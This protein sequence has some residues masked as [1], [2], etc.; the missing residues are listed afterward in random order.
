MLSSNR[1]KPFARFFLGVLLGLSLANCSCGKDEKTA[2]IDRTKRM[3]RDVADSQDSSPEPRCR[4]YGAPAFRNG[5]RTLEEK[6]TASLPMMLTAQFIKG[7]DVPQNI[8]GWTYSFSFLDIDHSVKGFYLRFEG[9]PD[10]EI[11]PATVGCYNLPQDALVIYGGPL[12]RNEGERAA[13]P[14]SLA[15]GAL[16]VDEGLLSR[17]K[18][19]VGL[20]CV[21]GRKLAPVEAYI[22]Q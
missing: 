12:L 8:T 4:T 9:R 10:V 16:V 7:L 6:G 3:M 22:G 13:V 5:L 1:W 14:R 17:K 15:D 2:I 21:D 19:L 18:L 11:F 20:I